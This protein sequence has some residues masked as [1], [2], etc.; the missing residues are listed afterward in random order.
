[1]HRIIP[2][3]LLA[4]AA[5]AQTPPAKAVF[6]KP[7]PSD[8][9]Q[10]QAY[11]R[12]T[13]REELARL[14]AW[15]QIPSVRMGLGLYADARRIAQA[16]GLAPDQPA[17]Y[18]ISLEPGGN[19]PAV[20]FRLRNGAAV[21]NHAR[22]AFIK[23][24]PDEDFFRTTLLHETGHIALAMLLG[25]KRFRGQQMASLPH[26][27]AAL[28]D[29]GTAFDEGFGIHLETA[30][31]HFVDEP[32]MRRRYRHEQFLFGPAYGRR[33]EYSRP[34][35]D[36]MNFAQ[37][38]GRY[39]DVRENTFAFESAVQEPDYVRVQYEKSRDY[40]TLRDANQLLQSE[41]FYATFFFCLLARGDAPPALNEV[42]RRQERVLEALADM[43]AARPIDAGAPF[44]LYFVE[45]Y[46]KRYPEEKEQ[47]LDLLLDLSHGVFVDAG[48]HRIW[49]EYYLA[50]L[51]LDLEKVKSG[52]MEAVR[53]KWREAVLRDPEVLYSRL[54]PQIP[55]GV[56]GTQ[57][58]LVAFKRT[59]PLLFD[60]NTVQKSVLRMIPG[61]GDAEVSRWL[62][63]RA[64][65]PFAGAEDFRSRAALSDSVWARLVV[66]P[67][68]RTGPAQ[69]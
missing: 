20:G 13:D 43:F 36:L 58:S 51:R 7:D 60:A 37:E 1:M 2:F 11:V 50:A 64:Q 14:D 41:G 26:S 4:C 42:R 27:N 24:A 61:I 69:Q 49:R 8:T 3:T 40:A 22:A 46:W 65:Q 39:Y 48:A 9:N 28:S 18:H 55:C 59:Q 38:V 6:M 16:R 52:E 29:R 32:A 44:L 23:L 25:G 31:A 21:E 45:S 17:E 68:V 67:Q 62:E 34:A 30:A 57:V 63:Q 35:F 54:G 47:A 15:L 10:P 12:V 5:S 56:K 19:F 53:K 66:N 33:S